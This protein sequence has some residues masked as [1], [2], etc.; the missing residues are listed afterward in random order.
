M[1]L[2][3]FKVSEGTNPGEDGE[4]GEGDGGA[5]GVCALLQRVVLRFCHLPLIGHEAEAHKP[6]EGPKC[7]SE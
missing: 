7:W 6:D 4:E 5:S 3:S 1:S 2:F